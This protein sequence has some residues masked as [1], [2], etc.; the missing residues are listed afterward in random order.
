MA[1]RVNAGLPY[2]AIESPDTA[3]DIATRRTPHPKVVVVCSSGIAR[4]AEDPGSVS[5]GHR[6]VATYP[7]PTAAVT[8][9]GVVGDICL[10]A[11]RN[12]DALQ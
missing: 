7:N 5:K 4:S 12:H 9:D 6:R 11:P 3:L 8:I 2:D 10:R 1:A